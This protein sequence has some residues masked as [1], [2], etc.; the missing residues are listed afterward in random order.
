MY[1]VKMNDMIGTVTHK[2]AG[3]F[4]SP[5]EKVG[6]DRTAREL[7]NGETAHST[8]WHSFTSLPTG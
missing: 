4:R 3:V 5:P 8:L 1:H 7:K 2:A 6:A